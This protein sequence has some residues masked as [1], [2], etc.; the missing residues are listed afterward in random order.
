MSR[1]TAVAARLHGLGQV[2]EIL[3]AMKNISLMEIRELSTLLSHQRAA[4]QTIELA[5]A[6]FLAFHIPPVPVPV[7]KICVVV[8]T[9]RGFCGDFNET[10]V[11]PAL[12]LRERGELLLVVGGKLGDHLE[13]QA[14]AIL[15]G[16]SIARELAGVLESVAARLVNEQAARA[17]APLQ[18]RVLYRDPDADAPVERVILPLPL[19]QTKPPP[20]AFPPRL[21][22]PPEQFMER[23]AEQAMLMSM[24]EVFAGSLLAENRRRLEHMD[25][26]LRRLD[27]I[28]EDLSRK[29]NAYRQED[30]TMEIETIMLSAQ[31]IGTA[32]SGVVPGTSVRNPDAEESPT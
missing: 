13:T 26:A 21:N 31:A 10:L 2:R 4:M 24:K 7:L 29:L 23:L 3:G 28:T 15:D 1:R 5:A 8:G 25:N 19:P 16:A 11:A 17:N 32:E 22:L 6:D 14:L 20:R 9:E 18:V 27:R 30:I 12:D